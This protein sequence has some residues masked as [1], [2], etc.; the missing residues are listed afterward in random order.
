MEDRLSRE[1]KD[2]PR[3][4]S[5]PFMRAGPLILHGFCQDPTEMHQRNLHTRSS[6]I[7]STRL[8]LVVLPHASSHFIFPRP[9]T[10]LPWDVPRASPSSSSRSSTPSRPSYAPIARYSSPPSS[11]LNSRRNLVSPIAE[12]F[13]R[14]SVRFREVHKPIAFS[15][16][17]NG[18]S[19]LR[20]ADLDE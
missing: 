19:L 6:G 8:P 3:L 2:S 7:S 4:L 15:A 16:P 10:S 14:R 20:I 5:L 1:R 13:A 18:D 11:Y 9:S 17:N 12:N